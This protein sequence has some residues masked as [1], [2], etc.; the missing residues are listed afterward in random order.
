MIVRYFSRGIG[1]G[2]DPVDYLL[3]KENERENAELLRGDP[4]TTIDLIDSLSFKKSYTSGVLAF[5]GNEE[6]LTPEIKDQIMDDFERTTFAGLGKDQYSC[7]W[8]QHTDKKNTEL[9]FVIPNVELSTGKRLQPYY[10]K[11]DRARINQFRDIVNY[12]HDLKHPELNRKLVKD[13]LSQK[14]LPEKVKEIK[15]QLNNHF[16]GA[17]KNGTITN[18]SEM[19]KALSKAGWEIS[20]D[21]DNYLS[22]KNPNGGKNIRLPGEIYGQAFQAN[23]QSKNRGREN[24]GRD[25]VEMSGRLEQLRQK[26]RLYNKQKAEYNR[27]RYDREGKSVLERDTKLLQ[28]HLQRDGKGQSDDPTRSRKDGGRQKEVHSSTVEVV[29]EK[30]LLEIRSNIAGDIIHLSSA[31]GVCSNPDRKIQVPRKEN[32]RAAGSIGRINESEK[33]LRPVGNIS[34]DQRGS[35]PNIHSDSRNNNDNRTVSM[36]R[37]QQDLYRDNEVKNDRNRNIIT[38]SV[39]GFRQRIQ[40]RSRQFTEGLRNF[41]GGIQEGIRRKYE[42]FKKPRDIGS[43]IGRLTKGIEGINKSKSINHDHDRGPGL[44]R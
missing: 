29:S 10:D 35:R 2:S 22:L 34:S 40:D 19:R 13:P 31:V 17:V 8:V 32:N 24:S 3:G 1:S 33:S 36:G 20:R 39:R 4:Q 44:S 30:E 12:T 42:H 11:V 6:K 5:D 38:E 15:E 7:L 26:H 21:G 37:G 14:N 27:E 43:E 28:Q 41:V 23:E 18:S 9:H 16:I 25:Q